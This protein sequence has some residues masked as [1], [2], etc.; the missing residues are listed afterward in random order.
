MRPI[1]ASVLLLGACAIDAR[2]DEIDLPD[3]DDPVVEEPTDPLPPGPGV[4]ARFVPDLCEVRSALSFD[5]GLD[6]KLAVS[7]TPQGTAVFAVPRFGGKIVGV[8]FD[9]RGNVVGNPAGMQVSDDAEYRSVAASFIDERLITAALTAT[10]EINYDMHR[11][12]LGDRVRIGTAQGD[13]I[14]DQAMLPTAE[15]RIAAFGIGEDVSSLAFGMDWRPAEQ[16]S[17]AFAKV[18]TL[19]ASRFLNDAAVVWSTWDSCHVQALGIGGEDGVYQ[20]NFAC[21]NARVAIDEKFLRGQIVFERDG[22]IMRA[23]VGVRGSVRMDDPV[24]IADEGYA[25]QIVWDGGRYWV[26]YLDTRGFPVV[27]FLDEDLQLQTIGLDALRPMDEA[28]QLVVTEGQVWL[29]SVDRFGLVGA[30]V[31]AVATVPSTPPRG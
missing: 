21:T 13:V 29:Y 23:P 12:D 9:H 14:A 10:G 7:G 19:G 11:F 17:F 4:E 6:V 24:L 26:S 20:R 25:P 16:Q 18:D 28:M 1:F 27:G 31:C 30:H 3:Q 22:Q 2:P 15:G 8:T 5:P